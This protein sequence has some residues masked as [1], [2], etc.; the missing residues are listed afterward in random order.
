MTSPKGCGK[1][2]PFAASVSHLVELHLANVEVARSSLATRSSKTLILRDEG[3]LFARLYGSNTIP[4]PKM[5][6]EGRIFQMGRTSGVPGNGSAIRGVDG[7]EFEPGPPPRHCAGRTKRCAP[8]PGRSAP[9]PFSQRAPGRV[10]FGGFGITG[11]W[12]HR[13]LRTGTRPRT[14]PHSLMGPVA[15]ESGRLLAAPTVLPG[16]PAQIGAHP[17]F[18]LGGARLAPWRPGRKCELPGYC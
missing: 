13:P 2:H 12:G 5:R 11:R 9:L 7:S 10:V 17:G 14:V 1:K 16:L 18:S 6:P 4:P 15:L 3:F 8:A